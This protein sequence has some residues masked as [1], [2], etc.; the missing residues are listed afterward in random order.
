MMAVSE[1]FLRILSARTPAHV[2][3]LIRELEARKAQKGGE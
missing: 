2:L 1:L 3:G